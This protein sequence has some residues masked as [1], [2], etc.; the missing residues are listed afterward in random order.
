M[1]SLRALHRNPYIILALV[2][3]LISAGVLVERKTPSLAPFVLI[4]IAV[5]TLMVRITRG[6]PVRMVCYAALGLLSFWIVG[7]SFFVSPGEEEGLLSF[8]PFL[9]LGVV[10]A[11]LVLIT[12]SE[13]H[14]AGAVFAGASVVALLLSKGPLDFHSIDRF[15]I[16][17]AL[18]ASASYIY[19]YLISRAEDVREAIG[20][21]VKATFGSAAL[22]GIVFIIR[23]FDVGWMNLLLSGQSAYA[24]RP[25]AIF[26]YVFWLALISNGFL[27]LIILLAYEIGLSAFN[28][29]R[30]VGEDG[31]F[32][33]KTEGAGEPV[34]TELEGEFDEE[35]PYAPLIKELKNF[36]RDAPR[37][38]DKIKATEML[39]RF[40]KEF[41]LLSQ[42]HDTKS[43]G[44]AGELLRQAEKITRGIM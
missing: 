39:S 37:K 1:E 18:F 42:K 13:G 28:L 25:L 35:D 16:G 22:L 15:L 36:A 8:L 41:N 20:A 38:Y 29:R 34:E 14:M 5:A 44:S 43:K 27:T 12:Y 23:I 24:S 31:V 11:V 9:M 7:N 30:E 19:T 6:R 33:V 40:R 10:N 26:I 3:A 2:F 32:Y 21:I 17:V 4:V